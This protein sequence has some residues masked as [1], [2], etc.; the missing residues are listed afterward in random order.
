LKKKWENE[1]SRLLNDIKSLN[2]DITSLSSQIS[3]QVNEIKVINDK[4]G[5]LE[6]LIKQKDDQVSKTNQE[7][8]VNYPKKTTNNNILIIFN[9]NLDDSGTRG[10]IKIRKSF[11]SPVGC[12]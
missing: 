10:S 8:I 4:N 3:Q 2:N 9:S 1:R 5:C 6:E 7:L 11:P 12:R